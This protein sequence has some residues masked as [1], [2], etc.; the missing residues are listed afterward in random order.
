MVEE[1]KEYVATGEA[2]LWSEDGLVLCG[3]FARLKHFRNVEYKIR[4]P[5]QRSSQAVGT[6]KQTG[7]FKPGISVYA[8]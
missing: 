5:P 2:C 1:K 6:N 7:G 4:S 3:C 8:R